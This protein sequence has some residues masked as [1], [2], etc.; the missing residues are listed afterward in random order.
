MHFN[1]PLVDP[2]QAPT[3]LI[4]DSMSHIVGCQ[5]IKS[6]SLNP[7]VLCRVAVLKKAQRKAVIKSMWS[8]YIR[9]P[10]MAKTATKKITRTWLLV[11]LR[12][13]M[14]G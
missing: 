13:R 3:M 6:S 14:R 9:M 11:A 12:T 10:T 5:F 7:V 2:A 4:N 8:A 1:P